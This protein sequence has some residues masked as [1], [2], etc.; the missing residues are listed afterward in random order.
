MKSRLLLTI[1][2][3]LLL[4]C[5]NRAVAQSVTVLPDETQPNSSNIFNGNYND[6]YGNS[7][8][9]F[10][11]KGMLC[12]SAQMQSDGFCTWP[13]IRVAVEYNGTWY[14]IYELW[15]NP[16]LYTNCGSYSPNNYLPTTPAGNTTYRAFPGVSQ[17]TEVVELHTNAFT[18]GVYM[19]NN[20]NLVR[21]NGNYLPV[22]GDSQT[23]TTTSDN[24]AFSVQ[25]YPYAPNQAYPL[26]NPGFNGN[27]AVSTGMNASVNALSFGNLPGVTM[28]QTDNNHACVMVCL[29][30]LPPAMLT[31]PNFRVHV[32]SNSA[33]A[34]KDNINEVIYTN[35][36]FMTSPPNGLTATQDLCG[37]VNLTWA[38][39]GANVFPT[40]GNAT[41]SSVIF[42]NG[43]YLATV[44]GTA[45]SYSDNTVQ[46]DVVYQ[47]TMEH[48]A[49]S[50]SGL[51]YFE[52][53]KTAPVSG[54][55]LP[56][57]NVPL[58]ATATTNDCSGNITLNWGYNGANPAQF[59]IY[60]SNT[61][62]GGPFNPGPYPTA[63]D[64]SYVTV[65][66][67]GVPFN[68]QISA[69]NACGV[70]STTYASCAG[71]SPADP[72]MSTNITA[73]PNAG[74]GG[75][76]VS[77][78]DNTGASNETKVEVVRTD[79]LGNTV[80]TDLNAGTTSYSDLAVTTC[81]NYT[82]QI[83]VF[84]SCVVGGVLS[85]ASAT[86]TLPPPN[87]LN[88]FDQTSN[89][90][91]CSKGYFNDRVVLNWQNNN[92]SL[93]SEIAIYRNVTGSGASPV[94][95]ASVS[96]GTEEY[97]DNTGDA[98]ILYTYFLV[99]HA[100]CL[101]TLLNTNGTNDI[102]FRTPTGI[103]NGQVQYNGGIAVS[104]VK[105]TI[106]E[107]TLNSGYAA[108]FN[109]S[110]QVTVNSASDLQQSNAVN[111][112]AWVN[113]SSLGGSDQ[114]L[115]QKPGSYALFYQGSSGNLIMRVIS[116]GNNTDATISTSGL[117][118]SNAYNQISGVY[119]GSNVKI[120]VNGT[121]ENSVGGP[122]SMDVNSNQVVMGTGFNGYMKEIRI[123]NIPRADS[124]IARDYQRVLNGNETGLSL[125][126][127]TNEN[128]GYYLYDISKVGTVFNM[129]HGQFSSPAWTNSIPGTNQMGYIGYTDA[130]GNYT[131]EGVLYAGNGENFKAIPAF[132]VHTFSPASQVMFVGDGAAVQN[133]IN[134]TD[135]SS[136]DVQ[137]SLNYDPA[138][139]P[140]C[141]CP[142]EGAYL[143]VDGAVVL[144]GG[145]PAQTNASGHFDI[146]V[147][148]GNHTVTVTQGG[149]TYSAGT[150]TSNFQ[151]D[152]TNL[153]FLDTTSV[154]VVGRVVGG[155]RESAKP[156]ILGESKN[157]IGVAQFVLTT[158]SGC[159][160][161]TINTN[162]ASGDYV[163]QLPPM[164][165]VVGNISIPHNASSLAWPE[166]QNLA[167][168]NITNIPAV[169]K[170]YDTIWSYVGNQKVFTRLDSGT[171]QRIESFTHRETPT[172]WVQDMHLRNYVKYAGD[173]IF[174]YTAPGGATTSYGITDSTFKYPVFTQNSA[175]SMIM[176]AI[177]TYTNFDPSAPVYDVVPATSGL[178]TINNA[179][180]TFTGPQSFD[181]DTSKK[182]YI[183]P[184][185]D[186]AYISYSFVA[187]APNIVYNPGSDNFLQQ[188]AINYTGG[189]NSVN[190]TPWPAS[191]PT[192]PLQ[193]ILLGGQSSSGQGFV[194]TGPAVVEMV[195]RDPP[196]SNSSCTFEKGSSTTLTTSW[197]NEGDAGIDVNAKIDL[198]T[199]FSVG[200]GMTTT[201]SVT[202]ELSL[203]ASVDTKITAEGESEQT[204]TTTQDWSTDNGPL[205]VGAAADLYIGRAMNLNFGVTENISILPSAAI[206]NKTGIDSS[207]RGLT[208]GASPMSFTVVR[209]KSLA[210]V[211]Q[212]YAT[213][214]MYTQDYIVSTL[215]PNLNTLRN[216][217][218]VNDPLKYVS[219]LAVSDPKYGTNNDDPVWAAAVSSPNPYSTVDADTT[220][221]SYTYHGGKLPTVVK[222]LSTTGTITYD[223]IVP[224]M[225]D[226]IRF[227]NQQIRLWKEAIIANEK[228]KYLAY[229]DPS[230]LIQNYSESD[231]VD[232]TNTAETET[233][234]TNKFTWELGV[235]TTA[236][237]TLGLHVA[238]LGGD[239]DLGLSVGYVHEGSTTNVASN[240][241][242]FSYDLND[243]GVGDYFSTDVR[244]GYNGWGPIFN[245]TGGQTRCPYEPAD[246]SL[247]YTDS[248]TH[249]LVALG[250]STLQTEKVSMK[251]DG[252]LRFSEKDN[253]P[254]GG[255]AVYDL[256]ID[257]ITESTPAL[258]VIY[259][260]A[261]PAAKNPNGAVLT[262]D[263]FS[264]STQTYT[265]PGGGSIHVPLVLTQGPVQFNY[266]SVAVIIK[267][268]CND[269]AVADTI[270][271]SAH[272]LPACTNIGLTAPLNQ[273]VVN[274]SFNDTLNTVLS[275]YDVNYQGFKEVTFEYKPSSQAT[276]VPLQSW[277]M[278][279]TNTAV[280]IPG[281]QAFIAYPW[282]LL[283]LQDD[284]YDIRATA[285]CKVKVGALTEIVTTQSPVLSGVVDRVNPAPFGTP[286]PGTGILNPGEDISITYNKAIDGGSL[287]D[288]NFDIRGVLNG[289]ALQHSTS[290]AFDGATSYADAPDGVNLQKRD[291]SLEFWALRTVGGQMA[292]ISQSPDATN[293]LF[294]GFNASNQL[295]LRFGSTEIAGDKALAPV[296]GQW[297]HYA[298]VYSDTA[299]LVSLYGDFFGS[300]TAPLNTQTTMTA[301]YTGAG[302]LYF[303]KDDASNSLFF[304]GNMQDV[305]VWNSTR[306]PADIASQMNIVQTS[307]TGN[308]L[309]DWMMDEAS[310]TITTDAIRSLVASLVNTTWQITPNGFACAFDG[311]TGLVEMN[312][313]RL[314]I[315]QQ[316]DFT[317]EFWFKSNQAGVATLFSNG[318]GDGL[319]ADSILAWNIEK[320]AA[321]L[322]HVLHDRIDFVATSAN[323][324]DNNWH[325][326]ALVMQ[327]SSTLSAYIDGNPQ[328]SI[329]SG[330][331]KQMGGLHMF[332]G[333]R[334][335]QPGPP[336]TLAFD[337]YFNGSMDEV[338]LWNT[339]RLIQQITRDKQ[340]RLLGNE[341][342][343]VMYLPFESYVNNL[344]VPTM[345]A[346]IKDF[347]TDSLVTT[348]VGGARTTAQTPT[349]K[350]PR[351]IQEINFTYSLNT[352]E[353]IMTSTMNPNQIENVTLDVTVQ[354]AHD[355]DGNVQQSPKTWIAYINQ[356]QVKWQ[357]TGITLSKL[358]GTS[359]TFTGTIVNSGG[360]LMAYTIANMPSWLTVDAP[361]G[362]IAPNST[363]VVHFTISQGVNIGT[364]TEEISLTTSFGYPENFNLNLNVYAQPPN[365]SVNPANYQYSEGVVGQIRIDGIVHTDT[366]DILAAF[367]GTTCRGVAR[368]QY[369]AAYDKYYAVMNLFSNNNTGDTITFQIWDAAEGKQ[370]AQVLP[371]VLVFNADSIRGTFVSPQMFDATDYL[372]RTL[373]LNTGW[374]WISV[375][376]ASP[377]SLNI[378]HFM[379]SVH[380]LTGDILRGQTVYDDYSTANQWAG[381]LD[382]TGIQV[383][384]SY[385]VKVGQNDTL[386]YSGTQIDPTTR[387]VTL[388]P[389]WNWPG[390]ISLRNLTVTE[391][392]ASYNASAG[393]ILKGQTSFALY[394]SILGWAGSLTY[395]VPNA[396][397]MMNSIHGGQFTFPI[398]GING[399]MA[400]NPIL[401]PVT[402]WKVQ[403]GKF[404]NNMSVVAK[405]NCG[406]TPNSHL[407]LGAFVGGECRG[408][409]PVSIAPGT[410]GV[411]YL[412]VFSDSASEMITL[413]LMD[414]TSANVYEL[415]N[416]VGFVVN[417]LLGNL[418]KPVQLNP[419]SADL[420]KV[421]KSSVTPAVNDNASSLVAEPVP[422]SDHFSVSLNIP[423]SGP[424]NMKIM[425]VTGQL[426]YE[427]NFQ[428][429]S[430]INTKEL[431]AVQMNMAPGLYIVEMTTPQEKL[432]SRLIKE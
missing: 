370:H 305:R 375:D 210:I 404:A 201:T 133:G 37:S 177:E 286:S 241:T 408:V 243:Q 135:E 190:W 232:Y 206:V 432:V 13:Q 151:N 247:F 22:G 202:N 158:Q 52:S 423:Y 69:I 121:L 106:E 393:D 271:V 142:V 48:V 405:L 234:N 384:S 324:F 296:D 88:T 262:I 267:S 378:N 99:G 409:V 226:S 415:G 315:T 353:I 61:G 90:L 152:I 430:G 12:I 148:I 207:E 316:M 29:A 123:W 170:I 295:A 389:G 360:S 93:L 274:N 352:D 79:N 156:M 298:A 390:F 180:S 272:F 184:R 3:L 282:S 118:S 17:R 15:G 277:F 399:H 331:F 233:V 195:L 67:R 86:T 155:T 81:T 294:F 182:A 256:E 124:D 45:T 72:S 328:N 339:A 189:P 205:H 208:P 379:S 178:F 332:V 348:V 199:E 325:H 342:G 140:G 73:S 356:N 376:V 289:T 424:V 425:N 119:D 146:H 173:S 372:V 394:D 418:Q 80:L 117:V 355:L 284:H 30:N 147:P 122:G 397:Y 35:P 317:L 200:F 290:L 32:Y 253:V 313:S 380:A 308:L 138:R 236:S 363:Q 8:N 194:S 114:I 402:T 162:P 221:M 139:F 349:I 164:S 95:I 43:T 75:I 279:T 141:T 101:N 198:G 58:S 259:A 19:F 377:D 193:G 357:N 416:T 301:Y 242:S 385:K 163:I 74:T 401:P 222:V 186:T 254:A 330:A 297:H 188:L 70:F 288:Y 285:T 104:G 51:T 38:N 213:S 422:F 108:V 127:H 391:A 244:S 24:A 9:F 365:W 97:V 169:S 16:P 319:G 6:G 270:Y 157:N 335:S 92:N 414:E 176:G 47:Y 150:Y 257:N 237:L 337:N 260:M 291:F 39:S 258:S 329:A 71:I 40:D 276:W 248:I 246:S 83:R 154:K 160:T 239:L 428:A 131:V 373:P 165:Y 238:G 50:E 203:G 358:L 137:G 406:G 310:G 54:Q 116:G 292:V 218:F 250:V 25:T 168:L 338:R 96:P 300:G 278:D 62:P 386:V 354:N 351:P 240:K 89:F 302:K 382:H 371:A 411:F 33:G 103:V 85:S 159:Y 36:N 111:A 255:Q 287:T 392:L 185:Q 115:I 311:S 100:P 403:Q 20:N 212:G 303:G 400:Q 174:N 223:S 361:T 41:L 82:Y 113:F 374:N 60:W 126:Y 46:Q 145:V 427:T 413:K 227:Y 109:G 63:Q 429:L 318:R 304:N 395:M 421:C 166:F 225:C 204:I 91:T 216:Q 68:F 161:Q 366:S 14:K 136:F 275:G 5:G 129:N 53:P 410:E 265:V 31:A 57:P 219:K 341:A 171:Y 235:S 369:Y 4:V 412:T 419:K 249:K 175:Y 326:F 322:I 78:A 228:E 18:E 59:Q 420:L 307:N 192:E 281:T 7:V 306:Q 105:V 220:G 112:E 94:Q 252:N 84:N 367:A 187:G 263:G 144:A 388:S 314:G 346:S 345:T 280:Q 179:L 217:L 266:D 134:F 56:S 10:K 64:R 268:A 229:H 66:G 27:Q 336:V 283:Q 125:L 34:G 343:L 209:R 251:V 132:G 299:R 143:N 197:S 49:F 107:T 398:T 273:W 431:S 359:L 77:W 128:A 153:T 181:Q 264:P 98:G 362:N 149:H 21:Y 11:G 344:G 312:T 426:V 261:I 110:S 87:L 191:H 23:R 55:S 293:S 320:D 2:T 28:V 1:G 364:Y 65:D 231:G 172:I 333:A 183:S 321:G 26:S 407:S 230:N 347:S 224:G 381:S 368:L 323:F 350:V 102:G 383:T 120:Y 387:N 130:T 196:G 396:G 211:P 167:L 214:F 417:G 76:D 269:L 44:S 42:R 334:G 340:N 245:L 215:L 309:Y 327:R